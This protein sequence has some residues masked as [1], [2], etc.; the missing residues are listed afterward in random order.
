MEPGARSHFYFRQVWILCCK[1]H[2]STILTSIY[3]R[4]GC[5]NSRVPV[6]D[7]TAVL[8][9]WDS[10]WESHRHSRAMLHPESLSQSQRAAG[11]PNHPA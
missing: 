9:Q 10:H 3:R 8:Q 2:R 11:S 4:G 5:Q 6:P 7:P 1:P